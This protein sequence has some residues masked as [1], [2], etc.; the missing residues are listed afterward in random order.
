MTPALA[1]QAE[2]N[3]AVHEFRAANSNTGAARQE[4]VEPSMRNVRP[5]AADEDVDLT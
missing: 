1:A 5:T 3:I 4:Q 2:M